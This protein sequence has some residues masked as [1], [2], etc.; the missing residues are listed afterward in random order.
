M[1][2]LQ[3]DQLPDSSSFLMSIVKL[4]NVTPSQVVPALQPFAKLPNS[5]IAVGASGAKPPGT[6]T[7][8]PNLPTGL[9]GLQDHS[10][11]IL[12][13]YSSNV[14]RMLQVLEKLEQQ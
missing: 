2:E 14:K 10:T 11:L 4:K 8:V 7:A 9:F 13:D 5:I 6:R 12:R 3:P 1:V